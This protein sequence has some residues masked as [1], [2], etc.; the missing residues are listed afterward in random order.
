MFEKYGLAKCFK[1]G[2]IGIKNMY[3]YFDASTGTVKTLEQEINGVDDMIYMKSTN[4]N[5]GT[6]TIQVSFEVGTDPDNNTVFT[7]NNCFD[8]G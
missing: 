6:M 7:Q 4:S 5:D 1:N 8:I 3:P 2:G